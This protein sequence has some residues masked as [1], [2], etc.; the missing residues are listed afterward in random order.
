MEEPMR[1]LSSKHHVT[2]VSLRVRIIEVVGGI[3][4]IS[5]SRLELVRV[6]Y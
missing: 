4:F 1:L 3:E 6:D 5:S 2:S